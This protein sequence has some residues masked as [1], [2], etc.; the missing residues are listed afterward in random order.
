MLVDIY[1]KG[2]HL[3]RPALLLR[4]MKHVDCF[5]LRSILEI[6]VWTLHSIEWNSHHESAESSPSQTG[7]ANSRHLLIIIMNINDAN[8]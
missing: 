3:Y 7:L 8:S 2:T 1:C 4:D 5:R 6:V